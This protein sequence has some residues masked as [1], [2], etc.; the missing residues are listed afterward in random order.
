MP[1]KNPF[2]RPSAPPP[3]TELGFEISPEA[4]EEAEQWDALAD[5]SERG[6]IPS[7]EHGK[8][9]PNFTVGVAADIGYAPERH[10]V[11]EDRVLARPDL[12]L[13][14]VFDGLGGVPGGD[15]A[16]TIAAT[17]MSEMFSIVKHN[18]LDFFGKD[19]AFF[20]T[21]LDVVRRDIHRRLVAYRDAR[22]L[23]EIPK[24]CVALVLMNPVPQPDGT[25]QCFV[26]HLGDCRVSQFQPYH[27]FF[28]ITH[29]HNYLPKDISEMAAQR[30]PAG[31]LVARTL[32]N[33]DEVPF[34]IQSFDLSPGAGLLLTTDGVHDVLAATERARYFLE[35]D[36]DRTLQ[37]ITDVPLDAPGLAQSILRAVNTA[38][39]IRQDIDKKRTKVDNRAVI[40]LKPRK[41]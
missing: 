25:I 21:F 17:R 11:M 6:I 12:G 23:T 4:I 10:K 2:D 20:P 8:E 34:T 36:D 7:P 22:Y 14:G 31:N 15:I 13:Y 16:A 27:Q 28:D 41:P 35:G 24:T 26:A 32:G 40:V 30:H 29:D 3:Q 18:G 39:R 19:E 38:N 9:D 37:D 33:S 1:P 5:A